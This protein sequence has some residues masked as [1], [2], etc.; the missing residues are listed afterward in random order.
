M[1]PR[2]SELARLRPSGWCLLALVLATRGW[3]LEPRELVKRWAKAER[4]V[5][6]RCVGTLLER[7]CDGS[8]MTVSVELL[9]RQGREL[10]KVAKAAPFY[11]GLQLSDAPPNMCMYV[12]AEQRLY[13][14]PEAD[15][16]HGPRRY[17]LIDA[18]LNKGEVT[19]VGD[20]T[21]AGRATWH[22]TITSRGGDG[23][24][25]DLW[26][27]QNQFVALKVASKLRGTVFRQAT[28]DNINFQVQIGEDDLKVH[29]P[30]DAQVCELGAGKRPEPTRLGLPA[31]VRERLGLRAM[32]LHSLPTGYHLDAVLLAPPTQWH[33][34]RRRVLLRYV[35]GDRTIILGM[36]LNGPRGEREKDE[37][38][39]PAE[40]KEVK[41][42]VWFW[43]KSN[44]RLA[45]IG[46]R[47]ADRAEMKR[48]AYSVDWYDR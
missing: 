5:S 31:A 18:A 37:P 36:G 4:T 35:D 46:P 41:P 26:I 10:V 45:L 15:G 39:A 23:V 40:P 29:A 11:Q 43:V 1:L 17:G 21:I 24:V 19:Y 25:H 14:R 13:R 27:D 28:V 22:V 47:D 48:A 34:F 6:F 8:P 7:Q 30:A 33:A 42:G 32:T 2:S 3:A 38:D 9:R 44:V 20:E 16:N 12:P